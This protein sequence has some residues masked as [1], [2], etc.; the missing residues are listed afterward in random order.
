MEL[1]PSTQRVFFCSWKSGQLMSGLDLSKEVQSL[2]C[3]LFRTTSI[4]LL[5]N[6]NVDLQSTFS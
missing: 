4:K 2:T 1:T 6:T 5:H 3:E